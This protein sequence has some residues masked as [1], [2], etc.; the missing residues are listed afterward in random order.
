MM[1]L[2]P[3]ELPAAA[4]SLRRE[5]R[6]FLDAERRASTFVPQCDSWVTG[7]SPEFSR[8]LGER[9]WIGMTWPKRYGGHERSSLERYVVIEELLAAGAPV[10]AHWA[11]DRQVGPSLLHFGTETQRQN[12]LPR[13][14]RGELCVAIGL[15]ETEAGS[16]LASLR[17]RAHRIPG[18]WR[19]DG[20]KV[21]T[22]YAHVA[23]YGIFLCR[24]ASSEGNRHS[25][26]SQF[27]VDMKSPGVAVQPIISMD[28]QHHFNEVRLEGVDVADDMVLGTVGQGWSQ[29]TAELAFERSGPER[30]LS[31]L[32][33]LR[34]FYGESPSDATA[35]AVRML[36]RLW[37]IRRLSLAVAGQLDA[38]VAPNVEAALVKDLGTRFERSVIDFVRDARTARV[39]DGEFDRLL[40]QATLSNP[41]ATLRGGTTE[42]LRGVVAR[43]LG[44]R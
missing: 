17:S 20:A 16:D 9:G 42:V 11:A 14:A 18:G 27:I 29:I 38:G 6:D 41:G 23:Q 1:R 34:A 31:T 7:H 44:L 2:P 5:V 21:W 3:T 26:L 19:L 15:S 33:L 13:I 28:G 8:K 25:G 39:S 22:S 40:A 4:E 43:E 37:T 30:F 12:F 24:T 36:A 10:G 35:E 32:P